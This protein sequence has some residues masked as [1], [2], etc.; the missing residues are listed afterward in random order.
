MASG[1]SWWL[2]QMSSGSVGSVKRSLAAAGSSAVLQAVGGRLFTILQT[3]PQRLTPGRGR[4]QA[5]PTLGLLPR[6]AASSFLCQMMAENLD[7]VWNL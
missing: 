3:S 1:V 7:A 4:A 5:P 6:Q 2:I